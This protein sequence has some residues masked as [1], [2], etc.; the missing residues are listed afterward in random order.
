MEADEGEVDPGELGD[1]LIGGGYLDLCR[2][3]TLIFEGA[4]SPDLKEMARS[5]DQ[6]PMRTP[7]SRLFSSIA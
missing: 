4:F 6:P 7:I 5:P 3:I 1:Q 2:V